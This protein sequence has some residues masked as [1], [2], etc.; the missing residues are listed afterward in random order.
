MVRQPLY[1]VHG[2]QSSVGSQAMVFGVL[3]APVQ[4]LPDDDKRTFNQV[5]AILL[6]FNAQ[7]DTCHTCA[8]S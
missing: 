6:F 5:S 1:G 3:V 7:K 8:D 4:S 2:D